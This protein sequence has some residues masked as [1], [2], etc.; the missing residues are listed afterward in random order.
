M[1]YRSEQPI[2]DTNHHH[3]IVQEEDDKADDFD[4]LPAP[5]ADGN[6]T[7]ADEDDDFRQVLSE[8][9]AHDRQLAALAYIELAHVQRLFYDGDGAL[10]SLKNAGRLY[11]VTFRLTGDMG[12]R[13]KHQSKP[14]AQLISRAFVLNDPSDSFVGD[15]QVCDEDVLGFVKLTSSDEILSQ[16][17]S[18]KIEIDDNDEE[19][20]NPETIGAEMRSLTPLQPLALCYASGILA[21]NASHVL[22]KEEMSPFVSLVI[23][24]AKSPYGTSSVLELRALML[25]VELEGERGRFLE[26]CMHQM[27]ENGRFVDDS[28]E[29]LDKDLRYSAAAERNMFLYGSSLPPRMEVKKELAF[30]FGR[31]GLVRSAMEIFEELEFLDE[32]VDCL[33]LIGNIGAAEHL[34]RKEIDQLE[35]AVLDDGISDDATSDLSFSKGASTR[36]VQS[37]A[38]KRP[39]L[40]CVL[41]DVTR[42]QE[43]FETAWEESG[44][45][46]AR[47]KRA[48]GL[49]CIES[50]QWEAAMGHYKQALAINSFFP[51][52]LSFTD[53]LQYIKE[54][55]RL[56]PM[57]SRELFNK[58]LKT[59]KL[60]TT[61]PKFCMIWER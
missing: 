1:C 39:R 15:I 6:D 22:T 8:D 28:F 24:G 41:G 19:L 23:E 55:Y 50:E 40:L 9:K 56:A 57:R 47:A 31:N 7:I 38:T 43:H 30:S 35:K 33:R 49:M 2:E 26:R 3:Q 48:F 34:V 13:T 37:R 42:P 27:E 45:R 46:Y 10:A 14:T 16:A 52:S 32:L 61:W 20:A 44:H 53:A 11:R 36:A 29:S 54:T 18:E 21:R 60:G 12:V 58:H 5:V 4:L 25:R 51:E 17:I 59:E